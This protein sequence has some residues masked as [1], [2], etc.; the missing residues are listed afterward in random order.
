M[1]AARD[2]WLTFYQVEAFEGQNH[3]VD[4]GRGDLEVA[5]HV[6]LGGRASVHAGIGP[7]EGQILALGGRE[8]R[9]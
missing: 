8:L 1:D 4:G 2:A 3:L 5:L 9:A 6:G 7:Y